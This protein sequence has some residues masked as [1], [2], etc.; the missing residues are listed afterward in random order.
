MNPT[1][2]IAAAA[3]LLALAG[4]HSADPGYTPS[5]AAPKDSAVAPK[6]A[7]DA[8]TPVDADAPA[9]LAVPVDGGAPNG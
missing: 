8:A 3:A 6:D 7:A 5:D 1:R 9:D 2:R 4:C